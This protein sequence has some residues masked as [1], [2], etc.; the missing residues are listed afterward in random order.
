MQVCIIA[1]TEI[2]NNADGCT[3][4]MEGHD[5]IFTKPPE[6]TTFGGAG[7][8]VKDSINYSVRSDIKPLFVKTANYVELAC[9]DLYTQESTYTV[10]VIYRHP[11]KGC[12]QDFQYDLENF[13]HYVNK[14][15]KNVIIVGDININLLNMH[16][17]NTKT[18]FNNLISNNYTPCVT[19]PT[20]ITES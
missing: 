13:C 19:L 15:A 14:E 1:L 9:I 6:N 3:G 4:I 12:I 17:E 16:H 18:Y 5:A 7:I 20:R 10:I 11:N 8:Y 2:G